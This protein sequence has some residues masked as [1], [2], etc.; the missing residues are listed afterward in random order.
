MHHFHISAMAA[1]EF[2]RLQ[3]Y[4]ETLLSEEG[5]S[6]FVSVKIDKCLEFLRFCCS[7]H[8]EHEDLIMCLQDLILQ[9]CDIYIHRA[10]NIVPVSQSVHLVERF[11]RTAEK[12]LLESLGQNVLVWSYFIVAA[13]S[14]TLEHRTF[15]IDRMER[16]YQLTGFANNLKGLAQLRKIWAIQPSMRWTQLLGGPAQVLIM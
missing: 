11:K 12:V 8:P 4:A 7:L 6:E 10:K 13:E 15:F 9:A 3:L 14:T 16:L 5:G 1:D 2:T